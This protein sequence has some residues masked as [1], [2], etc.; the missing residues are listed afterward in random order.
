M[1]KHAVR[2]ALSLVV[3]GMLAGS[4]SCKHMAGK[5]QHWHPEKPRK[6]KAGHNR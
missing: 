1:M 5:N 3:L 2:I 4:F 6:A